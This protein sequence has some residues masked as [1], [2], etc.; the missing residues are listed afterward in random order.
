MILDSTPDSWA[1]DER[2]AIVNADRTTKKVSRNDWFVN[3]AVW[4]VNTLPHQAADP[5]S[6]TMGRPP[7]RHPRNRRPTLAPPRRSS[8]AKTENGMKHAC[9]G[10]PRKEW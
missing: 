1:I 2:L 5:T 3:M 4:V 9:G 10:A 7:Q 8:R 6:S